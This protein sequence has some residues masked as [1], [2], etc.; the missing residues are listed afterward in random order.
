MKRISFIGVGCLVMF[1]F[2]ASS[3]A[4]GHIVED[5]YVSGAFRA[6]EFK[7]K[8]KGG[9]PGPFFIPAKQCLA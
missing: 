7:E 9:G 8:F 3:F 2:C 4:A 5:S 6:K 1:F